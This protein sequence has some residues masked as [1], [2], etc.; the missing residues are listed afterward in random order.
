[1]RPHRHV[2]G[3]STGTPRSGLAAVTPFLTALALSA[4]AY[5]SALPQNGVAGSSLQSETSRYGRMQMVL[6]KTFLRIDVV[7]LEVQLGPED[8]DRIEAA[9]RDRERS[10]ELTDS[11]ANIS[12]YSRDALITTEFRRN[13]SARQFLGGTQDNLRIVRDAGLIGEDHYEELSEGLPVWFDF[14]ADRGIRKGDRLIYEVR[15]D[16]LHTQFVGA[17]GETLMERTDVSAARCLAVLG[18][19]FARGSEFRDG[20][21][22]S[23]FSDEE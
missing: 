19:Y 22:S 10:R 12:I 17:A 3:S 7:R 13:L 20:L 23:L 4:F 21:I 18:S 9:V 2:G 11:I 8:A 6:E 16:S 5:L 14:I 15:G 1:M